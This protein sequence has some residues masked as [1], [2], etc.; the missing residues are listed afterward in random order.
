MTM[1]YFV[2]S[3]STRMVTEQYDICLDKDGWCITTCQTNV[4]IIIFVLNCVMFNLFIEVYWK[5]VMS[6]VYVFRRRTTLYMLQC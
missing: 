5:Y 2:G 3:A 1:T 6:V 4:P